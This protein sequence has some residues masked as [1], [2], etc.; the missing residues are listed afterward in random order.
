MK[1]E[2]TTLIVGSVIVGALILKRFTTV[3]G[4]ETNAQKNKRTRQPAVATAT[5]EL[6]TPVSHPST[7]PK[8]P[9][10]LSGPT[11]RV[12]AVVQGRHRV[13]SDEKNRETTLKNSMKT[14][15]IQKVKSKKDYDAALKVAKASV[16]KAKADCAAAEAAEKARLKAK[17]AAKIAAI[18][19]QKVA[20]AKAAAKA[21]AAKVAAEKEAKR[22]TGVTT[23]TTTIEGKSQQAGFLAA[24]QAW[25]ASWGQEKATATVVVDDNT[26]TQGFGD[27]GGKLEK[28]GG[29]S[30]QE[31]IKKNFPF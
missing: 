3:L 17:A 24:L 9:C 2:K 1:A 25:M 10:D 4:A 16:T 29:Q 18:K 15:N 19:A 30:I 28:I 26:T 14:L 21:K 8:V 20:A 12:T 31:G 11:A 6:G 27:T 7:T 13:A 5:V 22:Q 23:A